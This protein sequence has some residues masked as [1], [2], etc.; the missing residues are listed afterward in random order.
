M[1]LRDD[2][3]LDVRMRRALAQLGVTNTPP[4]VMDIPAR[5]GPYDSTYTPGGYHYFQSNPREWD[6]PAAA[7]FG[8]VPQPAGD[9][10]ELDD[11]QEELDRQAYYDFLEHERADEN[12]RLDKA[13]EEELTRPMGPPKPPVVDVTPPAKPDVTK[14]YPDGSQD[15]RDTDGV[16]RHYTP[17]AAQSAA[18]PSSLDSF[19]QAFEYLRN[20]RAQRDAVD[21][22]AKL[23][24][25]KVF[26]PEKQMADA[27]AAYDRATDSR[28][29]PYSDDYH[30]RENPYVANSGKGRWE[31][32]L[33][34]GRNPLSD[35]QIR[36]RAAAIS[37]FGGRDAARDFTARE[38]TMRQ[39]YDKGLV[40]ARE[41]DRGEAR[42]S[43]EDAMAIAGAGLASPEAAAQMQNRSL[44]AQAYPNGGYAL[45]RNAQKNDLTWQQFN[46]M[47]QGLNARQAQQLNADA[48][49]KDKAIAATLANG[50]T[51]A[52]ARQRT[53]RAQVTEEEHRNLFAATANK[54]FGLDLATGRAAFDGD[55]SKVPPEQMVNV[56]SALAQIKPFTAEADLRALGPQMA[57]LGAKVPYS[58]A[59]VE[60]DTI[61]RGKADPQFAYKTQDNLLKTGMQLR[62]G[63]EAWS[64]LS[65]Q[66]KRDFA[67]FG[68]KGIGA[69]LANGLKDPHD[70]ALAGSV[71]TVLNN[72]IQERSGVAVTE[73]EWGRTANEI[74][75]AQGIW[76]PFNTYEGIEI[77]LDHAADVMQAR[78]GSY[79]RQFGWR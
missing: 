26:S 79:A 56:E 5:R 7:P 30:E 8:E 37:I 21:S 69:V 63:I 19:K 70:R 75:L 47:Q 68:G 43:R 34:R 65:E 33:L 66:G 29:N 12:A 59:K 28:A 35:G 71:W 77:Y 53:E 46:L 20:E 22:G 61:A 50:E 44:P 36:G 64:H 4:P 62:A 11:K 73:S 76:D 51:L 15:E 3:D 6:A 67:S 23:T 45:G 40:D 78:Y 1:G 52:Q 31:E 2:E 54:A 42:I 16:V 38:M 27:G 18:R 57:A 49:N 74:G 24:P 72:L 41:R 58:A 55:F 17:P 25:D 10:A 32:E 48:E 60:A 13:H 9:S 39:N 14:T